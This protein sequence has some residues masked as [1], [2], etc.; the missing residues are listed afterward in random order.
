MAAAPKE[1]KNQRNAKGWKP[2]VQNTPTLVISGKNG[3]RHWER[4]SK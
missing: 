4:T 1:S 3:K 2:P